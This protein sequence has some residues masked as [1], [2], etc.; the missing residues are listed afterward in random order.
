MVFPQQQG[1]ALSLACGPIPLHRSSPMKGIKP[2][3]PRVIP[4]C[5]GLALGLVV[6]CARPGTRQLER[7]TAHDAGPVAYG[8]Q[9]QEHRTAAITPRSPTDAETHAARGERRYRA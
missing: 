9:R 7:P 3:R 5:Y 8:S 2:L 4:L 6:G 1:G